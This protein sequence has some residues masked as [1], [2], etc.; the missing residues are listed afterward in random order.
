MLAQRTEQDLFLPWRFDPQGTAQFLRCISTHAALPMILKCVDT[1]QFS[2]LWLLPA[3]AALL[4]HTCILCGGSYHPALLAEH[5]KAHHGTACDWVPEL[6]PQLVPAV[7][8]DLN[9]DFSCMCCKLIFNTPATG[10]ESPDEQSQRSQLVQ[11][12]LQ[13]HCPVLLQAALILVHG[14]PRRT[15]HPN[16]GPSSDRSF[17]GTGPHAH[18]EVLEGSGRGK[19]RKKAQATT[20]SNT[21]SRRTIQA[22][23]TDGGDDSQAG[24]REPGATQTRL[25]RLLH[26]NSASGPTSSAFDPGQAVASVSSG[27]EAGD[28]FA[29]NGGSR[30][31]ATQ[32]SPSADHGGHVAGQGHQIIQSHTAGP[33]LA[34]SPQ[35]WHDRSV[36]SISIPTLACA[37][38]AALHDEASG[39]PDAQNVALH[40]TAERHHQGA[41]FDHQVPCLETTRREQHCPLA[42][43]SGYSP[44]RTL[45]SDDRSTGLHGVGAPGS[46]NEAP[47]SDGQ[48]TELSTPGLAGQ[49]TRETPTDNDSQGQRQISQEGLI[50]ELRSAFAFLCLTNEGNWCYLNTMVL[51]TL[52][53][54]LSC[55]D[56]KISHWGPMGHRIAAFILDAGTQPMDLLTCSWLFPVLNQ[57]H[58]NGEQGD[59][60][61][62]LTTLLQGLS[63][64]GIEW[65]WERRVQIGL[66]CSIRDQSTACSPLIMYIDP[67]QAHADWITLPSLI[68]SWH[69]YMGMHTALVGQPHFV[70]IHLDRT[71]LAGNGTT[72]KSDTSVD[73]LGS[74]QLPFFNDDKLQIERQDFQTVAAVAHLGQD[75]AGHY[76][77]ILRT[78]HGPR[79]SQPAR[80]LITDDNRPTVW[81]DT[82][83][84]WFASNITC[85]WLCACLYLP[86]PADTDAR[87]TIEPS[88]GIRTVHPEATLQLFQ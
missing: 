52:W 88:S 81:S 57:W 78:A 79:S 5:I 73:I 66:S 37:N 17:Q 24:C 25:F 42:D 74:C 71:N 40:G 33:T 54:I 41:R 56:F 20:T 48:Q 7:A 83:P 21:I 26:A 69:E 35:E 11:I 6:L 64:P 45:C 44:R 8:K 39:N 43:A 30:D 46:H 28:T 22:L 61:E 70:C 32:D 23:A 82:V 4:S 72:F 85:I 29:P 59:P 18:R 36:G 60:V 27:E 3:I 75:Q 47:F 53:T 12:H 14:L 62:F 50:L 65:K 51:T 77:S 49:R 31:H 67:E 38:T 34:D 10:M 9:Q 19:R 76:R 2:Q 84:S 1:R 15:G 58:S 63:I 68:H 13:H 86:Q 55:S 87:T 80:F 16:G